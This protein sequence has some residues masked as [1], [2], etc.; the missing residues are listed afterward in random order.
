MALAAANQ[1]E[2][3]NSGQEHTHLT[4]PK[5]RS[6]RSWGANRMEIAG[7]IGLTS[8]VTFTA[9]K[10]RTHNQTNCEVDDVTAIRKL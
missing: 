1:N 10:C 2:V 7:I 9:V 3:D 6:R 5:T 8:E 4:R